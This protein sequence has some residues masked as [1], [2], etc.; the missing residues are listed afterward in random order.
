V[1]VGRDLDAYAATVRAV[2]ASRDWHALDL[3]GRKV[4]IEPNLVMAAPA[5]YGGCEPCA[6][7]VRV[8][9]AYDDEPAVSSVRQL[10]PTATRDAGFELLRWDGRADDGSLVA[11]GR[12]AVHVTTAPVNGQGGLPPPASRAA[13]VGRASTVATRPETCSS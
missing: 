12:Y 1:G 7:T 9:R 6:R 4:V 11:P 13:S 2:A 8:L 5:D 10:A 3:V